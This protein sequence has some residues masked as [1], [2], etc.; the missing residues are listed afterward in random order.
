M[1][2]DSTFVI[3]A[4]IVISSLS[5]VVAVISF[6]LNYR[7]NKRDKDRNERLAELQ[8]RLNELQLQREEAIAKRRSSSIVEARH[9]LIG[10]KEHRIR[11]SN[12]GGTVA[13]NIR[14]SRG[15]NAESYFLNQEKEPFERLEPGESFD[16]VVFFVSDTPSKFT[17]TTHW[18]DALGEQHSQENIITW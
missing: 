13:N 14:C 5:L 3:L 12:T 9:V 11:I 1:S 6:I 17:I 10:L 15:E 4:P 8:V 7:L 18:V 2:I 16:E